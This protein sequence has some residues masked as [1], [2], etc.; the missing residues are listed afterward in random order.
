MIDYNSLPSFISNSESYESIENNT[1]L[2]EINNIKT[3]VP[4]PVEGKMYWNGSKWILWSK[5]MEPLPFNVVVYR[6][7]S[8]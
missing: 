8:K 4:K 7:K 5:L 6:V 1:G 2:D 3:L